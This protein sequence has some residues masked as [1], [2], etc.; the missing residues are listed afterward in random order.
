MEI[1]YGDGFRAKFGRANPEKFQSVWAEELGDLTMQEIRRG[2]DACKVQFPDFP[3]A[4]PRFAQLCRPS[5][6]PENAHTEAVEQM[7]L[8]D[9]GKDSWSHPSVFWAAV[10]FGRDL[11]IYTYGQIKKRWDAAHAVAVRRVRDGE[12]GE[13]R[14][15]RGPALRQLRR[16][17]AAGARPQA[18][19]LWPPT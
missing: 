6:D 11:Q 1:I 15:R 12:L 7:R 10:G 3:P 18:L 9:E 8:R 14:R 4:L 5:I 2:V 19:A 16:V 13:R 17:P